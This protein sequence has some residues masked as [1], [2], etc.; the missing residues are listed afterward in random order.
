MSNNSLNGFFGTYGDKE[1][2]LNIAENILDYDH[3]ISNVPDEIFFGTR[4]C[5]V[6][7]LKRV[8]LAHEYRVSSSNELYLKRIQI[9]LSKFGVSSSISKDHDDG[10][11]I[12]LD[13]INE[14]YEID[15]C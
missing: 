10:K 11:V 13:S 6:E 14:I 4:D 5:I 3:I 9:L 8:F 15:D 7:F 12:Y 2:G 1:T